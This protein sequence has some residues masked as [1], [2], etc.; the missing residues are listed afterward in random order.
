[1]QFV[2]VYITTITSQQFPI[3][4]Q[5]HFLSLTLQAD[6]C[7]LTNFST[8]LFDAQ[9]PKRLMFLIVLKIAP[10]KLHNECIRSQR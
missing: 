4:D 8:A 6:T 3:H 5:Q 1:M 10:K 7:W 9:L 2:S